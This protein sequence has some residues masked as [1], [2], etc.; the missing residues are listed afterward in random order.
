[1]VWIRRR[2]QFSRPR[3]PAHPNECRNLAIVRSFFPPSSRDSSKLSL[4]EN[5]DITSEDWDALRNAVKSLEHPSLAGR[6]TNIV[7]NPSN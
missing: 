5:G 2:W 7:A 3:T 4:Q 6:L 1:M